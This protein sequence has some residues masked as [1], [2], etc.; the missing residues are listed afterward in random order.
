MLQGAGESEFIGS[1]RNADKFSKL[2]NS[3]PSFRRKQSLGW[4][5][6]LDP[7]DFTWRAG[8]ALPIDKLSA[9]IQPAAESKNI[10]KFRI[11][12][13]NL[14]RQFKGSFRT[15]EKLCPTATWNEQGKAQKRGSWLQELAQ[16]RLS[17]TSIHSPSAC[18]SFSA[19]RGNHASRGGC[20]LVSFSGHGGFFG[21]H[22]WDFLGHAV[23]MMKDDRFNTPLL[24]EFPGGVD[25][26]ALFVFVCQRNT[27]LR[28]YLPVVSERNDMNFILFLLHRSKLRKHIAAAR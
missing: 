5:D 9:K 11:A 2:F 4:C 10:P 7:C 18:K 22:G 16:G 6:N 24:C 8:E 27:A 13:S 26:V 19:R 23:A 20:W 1:H 3:E 12:K 14:P 15:S 28:F 25:G 17:R 21:R